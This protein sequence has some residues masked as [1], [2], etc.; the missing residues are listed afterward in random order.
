MKKKIS[1]VTA[2]L[3]VLF[4][5]PAQVLGAGGGGAE[6]AASSEPSGMLVLALTIMS[7]LTLITMIFF[8]FRDNG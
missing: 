3:F 1:L 8:S 7:I 2:V 5:L 4:L 6:E